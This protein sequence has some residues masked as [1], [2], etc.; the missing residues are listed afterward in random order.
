MKRP[1]LLAFLLLT[2]AAFGADTPRKIAFERDSNIWIANL[3]GTGAKKVTAGASPSLSADG[4]RLAFNTDEEKKTSSKA[5]PGPTRHIAVMTLATGETKI[6]KDVPSDNSY[7]PVFSPDGRQIV[8]LMFDG[9]Q[10][11]LSRI[12][13]DG[14]N[15]SILKKVEKDGLLYSSPAW[16]RDGKSIF[17]QDLSKLYRFGLDGSAMNE[18]EIEKTFPNGDMSSTGTIDASPDGQHLL[19]G[20][21]MNEES[22]RKGW[23]GPLPSVWSFDIASGKS[24]RLTS[25][26]LFGWSGCWVDNETMVFVSQASGEKTPSLYRMPISGKEKDR[27]LVIK[28]VMS[29]SLSQ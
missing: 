5:A 14:T 23:E 29:P 26:K 8:F 20:I 2:C 3:D 24:V 9:K 25:S 11:Q 19:L 22:H 10:W 27:K 12:N 13:S 6:F 15:F 18:W 21:E 16:A 17:C 7:G 4:E 1:L 28:N